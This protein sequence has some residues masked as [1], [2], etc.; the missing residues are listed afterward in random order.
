MNRVW[1]VRQSGKIEREPNT[2]G[3]NLGTRNQVRRTRDQGPVS[4]LLSR[5]SIRTPVLFLGVLCA[6]H[7]K[8]SWKETDERDVLAQSTATRRRM[9]VCP[10]KASLR[11]RALRKSSRAKMWGIAAGQQRFRK[12]SIG[13]QLA[14]WQAG[15]EQ[16]EQPNR[17]RASQSWSPDLSSWGLR[18]LE[19]RV[20]IT[21]RRLPNPSPRPANIANRDVTS[22]KAWTRLCG[23]NMIFYCDV[24]LEAVW[25]C[26]E[27]TR[28][29]L[30]RFRDDIRKSVRQ[31]S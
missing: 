1:V 6:P 17:I 20:G 2:Q 8:T 3:G 25:K 24:C 5:A 19:W 10:K 22:L 15:W 7:R 26:L 23:Y 11:H 31:H 12:L 13:I 9:P 29:R 27:A 28:T 16:F 4:P 21:F 18:R 30:G 14:G